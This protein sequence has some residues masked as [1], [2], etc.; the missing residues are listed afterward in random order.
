MT[1]QVGLADGH[2]EEYWSFHLARQHER[3]HQS[4]YQDGY[5]LTA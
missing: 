3:V 1:Q 2:F 4:G 5:A